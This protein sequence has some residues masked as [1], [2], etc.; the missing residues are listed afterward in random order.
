METARALKLLCLV[1]FSAQSSVY[2][3]VRYID[4]DDRYHLLVIDTILQ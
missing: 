1:V 2:G 4:L 3:T